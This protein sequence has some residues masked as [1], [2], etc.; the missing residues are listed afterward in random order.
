M[1][2]TGLCVGF[3]CAPAHAIREGLEVLSVS[4]VLYQE[5]SQTLGQLRSAPL[6]YGHLT[7]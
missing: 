2:T 1:H 7:P 3:D 4:Q 5:L 6:R